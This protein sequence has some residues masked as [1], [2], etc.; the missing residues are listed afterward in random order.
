MSAP[1]AGVVLS[2]K[3]YELLSSLPRIVSILEL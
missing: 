1:F 3:D 2:C